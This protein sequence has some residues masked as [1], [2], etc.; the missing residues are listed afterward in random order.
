MASTFMFG[1]A[2][3]MMQPGLSLLIERRRSEV[4]RAYSGEVVTSDGKEA[5]VIIILH[6]L[7][8]QQH[9]L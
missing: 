8:M 9:S 7:V 3:E 1:C 4:A 5:I 6:H 2:V